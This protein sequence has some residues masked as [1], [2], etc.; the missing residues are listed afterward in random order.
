MKMRE[1]MVKF[2]M[3]ARSRYWVVATVVSNANGS[4]FI[5]HV[6]KYLLN[7]AILCTQ[8]MLLILFDEWTYHDDYEY[9]KCKVCKEFH[10][11]YTYSYSRCNFNIHNGCASSPLTLEFEVHNHPLTHFWKLIKFTCDLC[12]KEGNVVPYLCGPC[13]FWTHN[14]LCFLPM[15]GQSYMSQVSPSSHFLL[16]ANLTFDFVNFV[17]KK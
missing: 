15:Q 10:A 17:S 5:N 16:K 1:F 8:D 6:L 11:G 4:T 3:G 13:N 9:S 7:C 2:V 12:G 14:K